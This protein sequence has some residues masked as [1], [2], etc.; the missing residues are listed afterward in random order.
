MR[1]S[2]EILQELTALG[3]E[4]TFKEN[5][6]LW[7]E[8]DAGDHAALILDGVVEILN[9]PGDGQAPILI[10]TLPPGA[11]IGELAC[12][13]GLD[14]SASVRARTACRIARIPAEAFRQI[15]KR[16]ADL[17]EN[18]FWEQIERVRSLT[19]QVSRTHRK[20]ITDSLTSLYNFGFFRERLFLEVQRARETGDPIS[21][22][23]LDIDHFKAFN[24]RHGHP[25]G[26]NVLMRVAEILK[27]S[28]R[29]GDIVARYGGEEFVL[30]LYGAA[31]A[32]A[33]NLAESIRNRVENEK[34][35][36][37]ETQPMGKLTVSGGVATFPDDAIDEE[38][39]VTTADQRL[40]EAKHAGRNRVI[41]G[42]Y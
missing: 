3:E 5:E 19:K 36:G 18:L 9:E 21:I 39:L 2:A 40:Y 24:D 34:F 10:R 30:L 33:W 16:R 15:V 1:L 37:G 38:S 22:I 6:F 42:Y 8:G 11:L 31:P 41:G 13:E 26:N 32:D 25:E 23:I 20:A 35:T 27:G 12:L 7:R 28:S 14:R 29:R 17:L 4:R